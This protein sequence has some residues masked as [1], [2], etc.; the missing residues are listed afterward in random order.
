MSVENILYWYNLSSPTDRS[1]GRFWYTAA[2]LECEALAEQFGKD[3]ETVVTAVAALSPQLKWERNIAAA[4]SVLAGNY[5]IG[6]VYTANIEKAIKIIEGRQGVLSG[7]KVTSFARNILGCPDV[8]C[9]DTW[10]WRVWAGADLF[11]PPPSLEKRYDEIAEDYRTAAAIVGLEPRQLQAITWVT[12]RRVAN[13]KAA[14]GQL[15]LDI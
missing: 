7:P 3:L 5:K 10:A 12:I 9:V 1:Q 11:A 14:P 6:G 4:R 2:R 13:G 8:V 15:S